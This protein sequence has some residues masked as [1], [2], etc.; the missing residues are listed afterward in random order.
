IGQ[1]EATLEKIVA[2]AVLMPIVAGIGGNAAVPVLTL[3]VRGLALG[4][5]GSS[6]A[7]ILMWKEIRVALI[8]GVLIGGSVGLIALLWFHGPVLSLVMALALVIN[9]CAAAAAGVLLPSLLR[10]MN[11][12][13]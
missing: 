11:I 4:Q 5:V 9:F 12:A 2:L 7:G 8:N 10:R 3:M 13:P 6:N 1:F